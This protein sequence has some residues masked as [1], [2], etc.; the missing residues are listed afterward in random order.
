M[1]KLLALL[2]AAG[3]LVAGCSSDK[4]PD[5]A[6]NA[7]GVTLVVVKH[8]SA[9]GVAKHKK[10]HHKKKQASIDAAKFGS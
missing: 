8:Q 4:T 6:N 3:L 9:S 1:K 10:H 7:D 2:A 5:Q